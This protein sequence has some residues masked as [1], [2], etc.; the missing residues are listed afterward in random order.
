MEVVTGMVNFVGKVFLDGKEVFNVT[1]FNTSEGWVEI[2]DEIVQGHWTTTRLFGMVEF[3]INPNFI[4]A[5]T[6]ALAQSKGC[7]KQT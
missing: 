1:A 6:D 5:Y 3:T 2:D 7:R 4:D